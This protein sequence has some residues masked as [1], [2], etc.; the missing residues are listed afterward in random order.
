MG[1]FILPK[2]NLIKAYL[3][4]VFL[5]KSIHLPRNKSFKTIKFKNV[6]KSILKVVFL[7]LFAVSSFSVMAQLSIGGRVGAN[8]A[9]YSISNIEDVSPNSITGFSVALVLDI[10]ITENFSV[11]PEIAFIQKGFNQEETFEIFGETFT[12]KADQIVNHIDVPILAK[13]AFVNSETLVVY[14]AVGPVLGYAISG[15][16][17]VESNGEKETMDINFDDDGIN[18]FDFGASFGAGAGFGVGPGHIIVDLRYVMGFSNLI[19][20]PVDNEKVNNTGFGA[21]VGY[22]VPIGGE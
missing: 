13:Y 12:V 8:F 14:A 10:G 17:K 19:K 15:K 2:I 22:V 11:Q 6:M 21:S 18:R 1:V 3:F 20:D 7:A 16:Y 5:T 9:N 4:Y